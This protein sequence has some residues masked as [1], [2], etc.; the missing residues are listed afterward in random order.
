MYGFV[1]P[2]SY[3]LYH[4]L[5]GPHDCVVYC[6]SRGD[7]GV[8]PYWSGD[9]EED[10]YEGDVALSRAGSNE[11]VNSVVRASGPGG[12]GS[13]CNEEGV[14]SEGNVAMHRTGSDETVVSVVSTISSGGSGDETGSA[15]DAP[16]DAMIM[17][18]ECRDSDRG[19]LD[20]VRLWRV[21]PRS[22]SRVCCEPAHGDMFDEGCLPLI[23]ALRDDVQ[24]GLSVGEPCSYLCP[25]ANGL[26][27]T[28]SSRLSPTYGDTAWNQE[29]LI[30]RSVP[31]NIN[32]P[33]MC[34]NF[35]PEFNPEL[36][37]RPSDLV[38]RCRLLCVLGG[39]AVSSLCASPGLFDRALPPPTL[40]DPGILVATGV[41]FDVFGPGIGDSVWA[42][43]LLWMSVDTGDGDRLPVTMAARPVAG[44]SRC[45]GWLQFV[46]QGAGLLAPPISVRAH[47]IVLGHG[48]WVICTW[49]M[50]TQQGSLAIL[51]VTGSLLH[52]ILLCYLIVVC[53]LSCSNILTV[54][55]SL[56]G[57]L[58]RLV[59]YVGR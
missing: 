25:S 21:N 44:G 30:R 59:H 14:V 13:P 32:T 39:D 41:H 24:L 27:P 34:R 57:S 3:E 50:Y 36:I 20:K 1:G 56:P 33:A 17:L 49:I 10:V 48:G 43:P 31:H 22:K 9:D 28:G 8:V 6:V 38:N 52:Q 26:L 19:A 51:Q 58:C 47:T 40:L 16:G 5:H 18:S 29:K 37:K 12:P 7:A 45:C 46:T 2:D 4:D 55:K 23:Y 54:T 53:S 11:L 42:G 35:A 15:A